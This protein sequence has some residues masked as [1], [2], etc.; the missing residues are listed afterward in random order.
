MTVKNMTITTTP[1]ADH[2]IGLVGVVDGGTIRNLNLI[3]DI[4]AESELAGAAAGMLLN[5]ATVSGVEV[6]GRMA[7]KNGGGIVGRAIR[8]ATL[9]DCRNYAE[10]SGTVANVGGIIGAAYYTAKNKRSLSKDARTTEPSPAR[11]VSWAESSA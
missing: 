4:Q 9:T 7:V 2:A 3:V 6:R 10:I 11:P 8:S 5:G 1:S